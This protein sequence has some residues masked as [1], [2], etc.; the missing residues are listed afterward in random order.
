MRTVT[1]GSIATRL[2]EASSTPRRALHRK[3]CRRVLRRC[4]MSMIRTFWGS[5]GALA[6]SGSRPAWRWARWRMIA[7]T[8]PGRGRLP[9]R[10]ESA[11]RGL[12]RGRIHLAEGHQAHVIGLP[13]FIQ[14]PA[15]ARVARQPPA[16]VGRLCEGG[17]GWDHAKVSVRIDLPA[18]LVR[19][20]AGLGIDKRRPGEIRMDR[21]CAATS[22]SWRPDAP[23]GSG[24]H[25]LDCRLLDLDARTSWPRSR[26]VTMARSGRYRGCPVLTHGEQDRA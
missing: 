13:D 1:A 6:S 23:V 10:S 20:M 8:R 3:R 19:R 18:R 12:V 16:A 25:C 21:S 4:R 17:D 5:S 15:H 2:L 14:R 26:G 22:G 9:R 24:C 11:R 7:P